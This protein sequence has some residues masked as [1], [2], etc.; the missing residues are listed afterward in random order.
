[1]L[2]LL[3]RTYRAIIP[4]VGTNHTTEGVLFIGA[5]GLNDWRLGYFN[6]AEV[7]RCSMLFLLEKVKLILTLQVLCYKILHV[8]L[9]RNIVSWFEGRT[10]ASGILIMRLMSLKSLKSRLNSGNFSALAIQV[11]HLANWS[12]RL[13]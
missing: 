5:W 7:W 2:L 6:R 4:T 13:S 1:M 11:S 10:V 3:Y 12:I 8:T 9:K